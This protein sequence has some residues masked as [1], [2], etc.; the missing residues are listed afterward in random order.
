M[1][2]HRVTVAVNKVYAMN[3]INI[4]IA[5]IINA[6]AGYFALIHPNVVCKVFM[7]IVNARVDNSH[8]STFAGGF[9]FSR[10]KTIF[11]YAC[12]VHAR[13]MSFSVYF[14]IGCRHSCCVCLFPHKV[15]LSRQ[16]VFIVRQLVHSCPNVLRGGRF[17][18]RLIRGHAV[19]FGSV[20]C[21]CF[22]NKLNVFQIILGADIAVIIK[23]SRF[24]TLCM[25]RKHREQHF[26][27][28]Y[29]RAVTIFLFSLHIR[30]RVISVLSFV[31]LVCTAFWLLCL[32]F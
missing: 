28:S 19:L 17:I 1:L 4:A 12:Y 16:N 6:V 30:D 14:L 26:A 10:I 22:K 3:I 32:V 31:S 13:K 27:R 8:N 9:L 21:L 15:R 5:V 29:L 7:G 18:E 25:I 2:V 11:P 23:I 24:F 20:F